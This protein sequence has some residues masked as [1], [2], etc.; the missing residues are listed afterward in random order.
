MAN[1]F[2]DYIKKRAIEI[3]KYMVEH[4]TTIRQTGKVFGVARMT[5]YHDITER[6]PEIDKD[7]YQEVLKV[8]NHH[9]EVRHIR[10]GEATKNK[11]QKR[12]EEEKNAHQN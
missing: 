2:K 3:G 4:K 10:G 5:V 11:Y 6:L 1:N 7:L 8:L 12:L 9:K